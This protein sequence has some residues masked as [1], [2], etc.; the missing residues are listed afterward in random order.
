MIVAFLTAFY[1]FRVVFLAFFASPVVSGFSRTSHVPTEAEHPN[2][3][4]KAEHYDGPAKA[5]HY[6]GPPEGGHHAAPHDP[7]PAM[8][9]PLWVLALLSLGVGLYSTLTGHFLQ[10]GPPEGEHA[11]GWLTPAAVGV[12]VAG[13]GLAWL[14]YQRRTID[15]DAPGGARSDR[16]ATPRWHKFLDR[17]HLRRRARRSRSSRSPASSAGSIAIWWTAC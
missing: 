4:A 11:P 8:M 17:R 2:G 10:F 6:D 9:L 15:A 7:P 5:G 1:M 14:V 13:I 16:F 3:P 12:A